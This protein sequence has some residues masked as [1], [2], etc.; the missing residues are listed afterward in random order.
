MLLMPLFPERQ[1]V[2]RTIK[3]LYFHNRQRQIV[4]PAS[5][6]FMDPAMALH[7][8]A[9]HRLKLSDLRLLQAVMQWGGMT[10][11]AVHLN[12]SQAAVSKAIASLEHA[13][14]VRLFD[15]MPQGVVPTVYGLALLKS[16]VAVFDDLQQGLREIAFL[17][18]PAA[19]E[20]RIGAT[21]Q[22]V[23]GF[24]PEVLDRL[25]SRSPRMSFQVSQWPTSLAQYRE[26]RNRNVDLILGRIL[27]A[28]LEQDLEADIL[29]EDPLL[30]VAGRHNRWACRRKIR[31]AELMNE[32]WILP[33][34][35]TTIG[36]LVTG[37][38]HA[39]GLDRPAAAIACNAIQMHSALLATGRYLAV[40][41]RSLLYFSG[42]RLS[43][44]AL[45]ITVRQPAPPIGIM[46]LRNRT[47]SPI[48]GL[49]AECAHEIAKPLVQGE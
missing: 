22:M 49:F 36:Q 24:L 3:G 48:A 16:G 45:P 21:E 32:P 10:K 11:A 44:K 9:L 29:F 43:L 18:D 15:R 41:P 46:T 8:R 39:S 6:I 38:F 7:N 34:P 17:A 30:I 1:P 26:L 14:G 13:L 4:V 42:Q 5:H 20:L 47:I 37:V 35:D 19:G 25:A 27:I 40:L 23:A 2:S 12:L 28:D 33:Q 31:L